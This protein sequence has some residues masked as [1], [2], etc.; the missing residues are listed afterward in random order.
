MVHHDKILPPNW[1][2]V[3][4]NL[5]LQ[6]QSL[7]LVSKYNPSIAGDLSCIKLVS[8]PAQAIQNHAQTRPQ[9]NRPPCLP[10]NLWRSE[11]IA[12]SSLQTSARHSLPLERRLKMSAQSAPGA[13]RLGRFGSGHFMIPYLAYCIEGWDY[14][15]INHFLCMRHCVYDTV[16]YDYIRLCYAWLSICLMSD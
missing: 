5:T 9:K 14:M 10:R 2:R 6:N 8:I 13:L 12:P 1:H 7:V 16:W 15:H 3:I 4:T 11:G